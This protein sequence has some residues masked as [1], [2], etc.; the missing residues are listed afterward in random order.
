MAHCLRG[1]KQ[2]DDGVSH[3]CVVFGEMHELPHRQMK[4]ME[5]LRRRQEE[6]GPLL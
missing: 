4:P 6:S 1:T 5:P 3:V 2:G